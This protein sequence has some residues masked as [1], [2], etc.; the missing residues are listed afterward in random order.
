MRTTSNKSFYRILFIQKYWKC[1]REN[2]INKEDREEVNYFT[3]Y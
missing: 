2:K 3:I 1:Q